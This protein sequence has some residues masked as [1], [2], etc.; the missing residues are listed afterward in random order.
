MTS[1]PRT[2]KPIDKTL[3]KGKGRPKG[4]PE[5]N[6]SKELLKSWKYMYTMCH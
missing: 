5:E 6:V 3:S 4:T 1:N 2:N